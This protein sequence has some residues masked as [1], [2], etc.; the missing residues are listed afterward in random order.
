MLNTTLSETSFISLFEFER[1]FAKLSNYQRKLKRDELSK[2]VYDEF[3]TW[4]EEL[5]AL[6]QSLLGKAVGYSMSQKKYMD[7]Y[8]LDGRLEISNNRAERCIRKFVIGRNNWL[9]SNTPNG[10]KASSIYYS[11]ILTA[12]ENELNPYEYLT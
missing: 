5:Y 3:Y 4:L 9:F 6:P 7:R 10:A 12:I 1:S 11:L 2:P 8:F